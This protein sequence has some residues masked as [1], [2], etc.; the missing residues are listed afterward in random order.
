MKESWRNRR[1]L[2]V[3]QI[4]SALFK[5]LLGCCC[6]SLENKSNLP[7]LFFLI[8]GLFFVTKMELVVQK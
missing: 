7:S 2:Q 3:M 4:S 5:K 1:Q 8:F 6:I